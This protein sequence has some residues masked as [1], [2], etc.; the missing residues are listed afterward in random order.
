MGGRE[1]HHQ[2][3]FK[4]SQL[5]LRTSLM[6]PSHQN[7]IPSLLR[8]QNTLLHL[9]LSPDS[10]PGALLHL[11]SL[12]DALIAL[13]ALLVN[14]GRYL[15]PDP[16]LSRLL[17]LRTSLK[18]MEKRSLKKLLIGRTLDSLSHFLALSKRP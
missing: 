2:L 8:P 12:L 14:G 4:M 18:A 6:H 7:R 13:I 17:S 10:V 16:L 15:V 11:S 1:R 9:L 3:L 5:V